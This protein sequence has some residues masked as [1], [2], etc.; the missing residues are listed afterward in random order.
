MRDS[1][2]YLT[3]RE[4]VSVVKNVRPGVGQG[5]RWKEGAAFLKW[6]LIF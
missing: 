6:Y 4:G 2:T 3:S 1:E 5:E